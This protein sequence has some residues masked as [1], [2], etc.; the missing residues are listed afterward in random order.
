[1]VESRVYYLYLGK[2]F[3]LQTWQEH[4]LLLEKGHLDNQ[5]KFCVFNLFFIS[6][7]LILFFNKKY[8]I[9]IN[10]KI[11]KNIRESLKNKK[12]IN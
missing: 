7:L 10:K 11:K 8:N 4:K 5:Y 9:Y 3:A 1:M 12:S 2:T 6:I